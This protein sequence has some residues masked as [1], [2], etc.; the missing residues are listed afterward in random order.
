[1]S[2][3]RRQDQTF[4]L[5]VEGTPGVDST[6]TV[7]ADAIKVSNLRYIPGLEIE[8]TDE[9][10][11]GGLDVGRPIVG[12]GN[13]AFSMDCV[14]RGAGT[15]GQAPEYGTML[16]SA[17][18][19][20]TLTA[21]AVTGTAQAGAASTITLAVGASSTDDAYKGMPIDLTGGT[22]SGQS[23]LITAYNGTTKVA[24][25]AKDWTTPPGGT[26]DYSIAA[27]ALYR[28]ASTGLENFSGYGWQHAKASGAN[29]RLR[30][31]IGGV[32]NLSF[33]MPTRKIATMTFTF[34]GIFPGAPTAV[35]HPGAAT[36]DDVRGEAIKG[37]EALL[38]GAAVKFNNLSFDLG[39]QIAQAD[40]PAATYGFDVA[41]IVRRKITGSINPNLTSITTRDNVAD[42]VAQTTK[43]IVLRWGSGAG[44]Q[45]SVFMPGVAYTGAEEEDVEGFA[46]DRVPFQAD[47][48][49]NG[50]WVC[51]Y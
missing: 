8:N 19:S 39:N 43:D 10:H 51:V 40:D 32:G 31:C 41:G 45:I 21:S 26:T 44:K 5:K 1:M 13:A 38:G 23:A 49:N 28:L 33:N 37:A 22:G 12:G 18:F 17:G 15:A 50:V 7:G 2:E 30:R 47:G 35:A 14:M 46:H 4:A 6:P 36:F 27:N 48:D 3:F 16:R 9:E 20:E 24:T 29:S 42:F 34:T 11:T 25:V